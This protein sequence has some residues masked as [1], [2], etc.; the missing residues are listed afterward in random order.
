MARKKEPERE[1][2]NR[3]RIA[4]VAKELFTKNGIGN[5]T[6]NDL[7]KQV[8]M[9]KSTLYVYFKSKEEVTNYL[10]FEAMS[11]LETQLAQQ[12]TDT[13]T[14]KERFFTICNILVTFKEHYPL[15]FQL[16]VEEICVDEEILAQDEVLKKIYLT[17]ESVNQ[18][19]FENIGKYMDV[20]NEKEMFIQI[21]SIWGYLYGIITLADNKASYI[22]KASGVEKK[23]FLKT[24]FEQLYQMIAWKKDYNTRH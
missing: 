21:F 1:V 2:K 22:A 20:A 14:I 15:N 7:A 9:S 3:E 6:M 10:S 19:L 13:L 8:G 5:T 17:G 24:N 23:E 11:Y 12:L 16:L 4:Q 18:L